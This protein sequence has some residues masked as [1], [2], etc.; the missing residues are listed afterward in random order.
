VAES[1]LNA[2]NQTLLILKEEGDVQAAIAKTVETGGKVVS[3]TPR[4]ETLEQYF[5]RQVKGE[6]K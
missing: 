1:V 2:D 3:L 5:I 6:G 4:T